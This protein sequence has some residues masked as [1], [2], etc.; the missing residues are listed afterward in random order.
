MTGEPSSGVCLSSLHGV[1]FREEDENYRCRAA[2]VAKVTN[3]DVIPC[4]RIEIISFCLLRLTFF[5]LKLLELLFYHCSLFRRFIAF[6]R[7]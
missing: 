5:V 1:T 3:D 2:V 6:Q 4:S 7:L